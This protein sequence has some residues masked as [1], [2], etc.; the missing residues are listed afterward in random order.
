[1]KGE[2]A[3][4]IIS[5]VLGI[6]GFVG[7]IVT[8][9]LGETI[10]TMVLIGLALLFWLIWLTVKVISLTNQIQKI[11]SGKIIPPTETTQ[12]QSGVQIK[13]FM[14]TE[15][16]WISSERKNQLKINANFLGWEECTILIHVLV[17]KEKSGIRYAPKN[18][19]ILGH[20]TVPDEK[21]INRFG[22]RYSQSSKWQLIISNNKGTTKYIT[23][24]DGLGQNE[25]WRQFMVAW[26]RNIPELN[27]YIDRGRR[28]SESSTSFINNWPQKISDNVS[29][30]AWP[31]AYADSFVETKLAHLWICNKFLAQDNPLVIEHYQLKEQLSFGDLV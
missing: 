31:S 27:F 15:F 21:E 13:K 18:K 25:E 19:Y 11:D 7:S 10:A 26:N 4:S 16:P 2:R 23:V 3:I 30:G 8:G 1:M 6:I 9:F 29:V 20:R 17:S 24:P 12:H 28:G 5:G 14:G 22:I